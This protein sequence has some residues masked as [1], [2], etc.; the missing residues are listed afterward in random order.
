MDCAA[1]VLKTCALP[2]TRGGERQLP[3]SWPAWVPADGCGA[4]GVARAVFLLRRSLLG[5]CCCR[6]H[7]DSSQLCRGW[8]DDPVE[9]VRGG[10]GGEEA[11]GENG[12]SDVTFLLSTS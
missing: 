12:G 8:G 11:E 4:D 3:P 2:R 9:G 1:G 5:L 7:E 10:R 6:A